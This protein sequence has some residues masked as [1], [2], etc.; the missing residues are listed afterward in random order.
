[1]LYLLRLNE[2]DICFQQSQTLLRY[3]KEVLHGSYW[4]FEQA[5][6][7]REVSTMRLIGFVVLAVLLAAG[8][9]T[10]S[11]PSANTSTVERAGQG[12]PPCN[13]DAAVVCPAG[14]IG[15]V[16][17]TVTVRNVYGD[18]LPAKTVNCQAAVVTGTF[19]FCTGENPQSGVTDANGQAFFT[20][21]NFGGCGDLQFNADCEGVSFIP[22]PTIYIASPDNNGSGNV[23]GIDLSNFGTSYG[24]SGL[25]CHD[26]N[27]DGTT[28]GL[29]LSLFGI[30]YGHACP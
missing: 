14:D 29:D 20:F 30:S 25:P 13:P 3:R 1:M 10:A 19:F 23:D 9:A 18:P 2:C 5:T 6:N 8:V 24:H 15:S 4:L 12:T 7:R 27:C 11:V 17:V 22:S 21:N 16:L 28:D 26:Y